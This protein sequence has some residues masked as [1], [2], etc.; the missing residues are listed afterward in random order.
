MKRFFAIIGI[1]FCCAVIYIGVQFL[2]G[3]MA[4][5][6]NT[7][8]STP[9]YYDSGYASFG[10][11]FYTYVNNNAAEAAKAARTITSNQVYIFRLAT[12]FFG[13]FL[14]A[15][16]GIGVC[17]F[18][19]LCFE[20]KPAAPLPAAPIQASVED[21]PSQR[22]NN[23]VQDKFICTSCGTGSTGWYQECPHCGA[24]GKMQRNE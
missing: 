12:Q 17:L 5:E 24:V 15:L 20:R 3:E 21:V 2:H 4:S 7:A 22:E 13:Y 23:T 18:G 6:P 16:G 8:S 9:S 10:G 11:D 14:I 1:L 19:V